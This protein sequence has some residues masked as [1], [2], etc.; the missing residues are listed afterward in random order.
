MKRTTLL[1]S[2]L[3]FLLGGCASIGPKSIAANRPAYNIAVQQTNDQE[4]LLNLVRLLYRDTLYFTTVERVAASMEFNQGYGASTSASRSMPF[5]KDHTVVRGLNLS[6][7][8]A[9]ND[10]PTVFYAPIDGEKFVRQMMTPMNP[11]LLLM[12]VKSGWSMDRVLLVGVQEMNGLKNAPTA[13]GPTPSREPEFREFQEAAKLLRALQR[14]QLI[15]LAAGPE[16]KGV[17]LRFVRNAMARPEA[18]RLKELLKLNPARD[19]FRIISGVE[20]PDADTLAVTTRPLLSALSYVSQGI[21]APQAH[22][23]AG[24][25][26]RTVRAD[27]QP[28]EWKELLGDVFQVQSAEQEPEDASVAIFYRGHWF[29]VPDNDLETKSTFVLLTQLMALHSAPASAGPAM[30][31]SFGK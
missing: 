28:F 8:F 14:E 30:S 17:E 7:S 29:F 13:A 2:G 24:K 11:D 26:R 20:A 27:Q 25:V 18:Q 19:R 31:F 15:D 16:G 23:E 5:A 3:A 21:R 4:L 9:L 1:L 6:S 22:V 10:K 12:L